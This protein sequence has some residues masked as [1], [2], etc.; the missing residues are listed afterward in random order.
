MNGI[1]TNE[2]NKCRHYVKLDDIMSVTLDLPQVIQAEEF[3]G[4]LSKFS[5]LFRKADI[6]NKIAEDIVNETES[7]FVVRNDNG[8]TLN[9]KLM[10]WSKAENDFLNDNKNRP[11]AVLQRVW[12]ERF[13]VN[14]TL[15]A[16]ENAIG[17][18]LYTKK[19][20]KTTS[21]SKWTPEADEFLRKNK[22]MS[23][24]QQVIELNTRLGVAKTEK[25]V[26]ARRKVLNTATPQHCK[27]T[28]GN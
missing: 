12:F 25:A 20:G 11:A 1:K 7:T 17:R 27:T 4:I 13:G 5:K 2:E 22:N 21:W 8:A 14:R 26:Y 18:M 9:N 15:S 28:G 3:Y 23:V 10:R 6:G 16:I 24:N 19:V